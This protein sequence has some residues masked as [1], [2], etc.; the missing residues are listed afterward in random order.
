MLFA[1][2]RTTKIAVSGLGG[3]GKTSLAI[4]LVYRTRN[5]HKD[6][7][8]FW[9]PASD[10]RSL[11][12]AFLNICQQLQIPGWEAEEADARRLVQH[13]PSNSFI[14]KWL[15]VF[16]NSDDI[17]IWIES[18]GSE[19]ESNHLMDYLPKSEDG[20]IILT[21]RDKKTTYHLVQ[22]ERCT[23]EIPEPSESASMEVL[24]TYL[25]KSELPDKDMEDAKALLKQLAFLPLAIIQAAS[26]INKNGGGLAAYLSLLADQEEEVIDPSEHFQDEG[27]YRNMKNP[28]T[29]T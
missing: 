11:R 22:Q 18:S 8:I 10:T 6:C 23:I 28:V 1:E 9:V 14:G 21:T 3:I 5:K 24:H 27:R 12:Q 15:L 20:C 4:E 25:N 7:S 26:Y 16:N 29:T 2:D 17:N 19:Q 13:Y